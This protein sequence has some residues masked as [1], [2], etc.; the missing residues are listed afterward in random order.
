MSWEIP[1]ARRPTDSIFWAW[2][3]CSSSRSS[4]SACVRLVMSTTLTSVVESRHVLA[5]T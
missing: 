5:G 2:R 3:S 1:P 4:S